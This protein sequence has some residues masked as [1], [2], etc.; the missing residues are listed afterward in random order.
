[1]AKSKKHAVTL[2]AIRAAL[3]SAAADFLRRVAKAHP[4]ETVY[5]F[6]FEISCEGFSVHGTVGTEEALTR[7]ALRTIND[8]EGDNLAEVMAEYRW[9][10]PEDA[11]YQQPDKAFDLKFAFERAE[12]AGKHFFSARGN[13]GTFIVSAEFRAAIEQSGLKGLGFEPLRGYSY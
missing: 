4:G 10:S 13:S 2:E 11:W 7:F 1:M 12:I 3:R 8:G 6:L 9:G 5:G